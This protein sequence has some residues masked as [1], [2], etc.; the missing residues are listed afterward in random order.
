MSA[1]H[2]S[3]WLFRLFILALFSFAVTTSLVVDIVA[4]WPS[5]WES[6]RWLTPWL[7]ML[8]VS[9]A[10]ALAVYFLGNAS[11]YN[12]KISFVRNGVTLIG[13][14]GS[15]VTF[16]LPASHT[17]ID[18]L[19][20]WSTLIGWLLIGV[21]LISLESIWK[22]EAAADADAQELEWSRKEIA[23]LKGELARRPKSPA[24]RI[25]VLLQNTGRKIKELV[26]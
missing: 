3:R 10:S 11:M 5:A 7:I 22:S 4:R 25:R 19:P 26:L 17:G 1:R 16:N 20:S 15:A 8:V 13:V 12:P 6:L 9:S 18:W 24:H 2:P 21:T 14:A 23:R